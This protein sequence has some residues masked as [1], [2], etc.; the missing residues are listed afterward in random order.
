MLSKQQ[1]LSFSVPLIA[2]TSQLLVGCS[3]SVADSPTPTPE[4]SPTSVPETPT[5]APTP[6][7]T[8]TLEPEPCQPDFVSVPG[9]GTYPE[10]VSVGS[11][12]TLYISSAA[13]GAVYR[14]LACEESA[15]SFGQLPA[16]FSAIGLRADE[17]RKLLWVCG[18][19][20]AQYTNPTLF[21]L[22][23]EDGS[24]QASHP[25]AGGFG[26]CNDMVI[27][28]AGNVLI[29][30]SFTNSLFT[31]KAADVLKNTD[32]EVWLSD[33]S[34]AGLPNDFGLNGLALDGSN[35]YVVSSS[36]GKLFR[37]PV[38]QDGSAG[39]PTTLNV[40]PA[41]NRPDGLA[42]LSNNKVLVVEGPEASQV[43]LLS[44]SG[45]AVA[46]TS[47]ASGFDWPTAVGVDG[48]FGWV[49]ESQFQYLLGYSQG[50]PSPF[51]VTRIDLP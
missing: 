12:G 27:D 17:A 34:M 44:I 37:V 26:V 23:L 42:L 30:E 11:Q 46:S 16:P 29:T 14:A 13:T 33:A 36:T 43:S 41:L 4:D 48:E 10:S 47:V 39:T 15:S 32:A 1:I 20:F 3:G 25:L 40:S 9:D 6:N 45:D 35:L 24:V 49:V 31:V 19:D 50:T 2:M 7:P 28:P 21:A 8:P 22:S 18:T 5:T 51:K 38:N